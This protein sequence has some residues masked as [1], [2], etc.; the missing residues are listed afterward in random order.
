MVVVGRLVEMDD[1]RTMPEMDV[2][3]VPRRLECIDR[4]VD[5]G[6]IDPRA[7]FVLGPAP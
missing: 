5:G 7:R 4:A 3:E 2:V 1:R 6:R